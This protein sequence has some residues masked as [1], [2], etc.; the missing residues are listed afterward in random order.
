MGLFER[1]S[2]LQAILVRYV[3]ASRTEKKKILDE[4]CAVRNYNRKYSIR[5]LHKKTVSN[6]QKTGPKPIDLTL[7][8]LTPY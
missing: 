5:L 6:K 7:K 1:N 4:F 2:Y 8:K 3:L